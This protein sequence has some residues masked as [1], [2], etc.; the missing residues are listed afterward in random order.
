MQALERGMIGWAMCNSTKLVAPLGGAERMLGT[1]PTP[2]PPAVCGANAA[3]TPRTAPWKIA[4]ADGKP[5]LQ[6]RPAMASL[7]RV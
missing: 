2:K 1:N 3:P 4:T 7:Y 6:D 5:N